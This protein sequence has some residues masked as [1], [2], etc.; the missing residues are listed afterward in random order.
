M[1]LGSFTFYSFAMFKL[2]IVLFIVYLLL[3]V[4]PR[5]AARNSRDAYD[6]RP[7]RSTS[8]SR[9]TRK[10]EGHTTVTRV[11]EPKRK[12]LD[13]GDAEAAEFEEITD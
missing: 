10:P 13:A 4:L 1:I 3:V 12:V 11:E 9:T 2:L 8:N 7:D 5:K 6:R